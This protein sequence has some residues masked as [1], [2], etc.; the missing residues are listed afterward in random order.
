MSYTDPGWPRLALAVRRLRSRTSASTRIS[1]TFARIGGVWYA[2]AGEWIYRGASSCKAG[3][4]TRTIGPELGFRSS[5]QQLGPAGRRARRIHGPRR[6][7][8]NGPVRTYCRR[9]VQRHRPAMARYEPRLA[10]D[11]TDSVRRA[12]SLRPASGSCGGDVDDGRLRPAPRRRRRDGR[13]RLRSRPSPSRRFSNVTSQSYGAEIGV[14][15]QPS[16]QVFGLVRETCATWRPTSSAPRRRRL[17]ARLSQLQS[18]SV[19]LHGER[20]GD[21]LLSGACGIGSRWASPNLKPYVSGG[22]GNP[23]RSRR[24]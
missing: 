5:V 11:W 12:N 10:H 6:V 18:G 24:T 23:R 15:V 8:R 13:A 20:A 17:P 22:V 16:L 21:L 4:G 19:S 14:T 2:G 9:A 3:Q 7:A 1:G